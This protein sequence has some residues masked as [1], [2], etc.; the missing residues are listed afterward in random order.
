MEIISGNAIGDRGDLRLPAQ[1]DIKAD[2]ASARSKPDGGKIR[3]PLFPYW[4][5]RYRTRDFKDLVCIADLGHMGI[6]PFSG[7]AVR[8]M[9]EVLELPGPGVPA[10]FSIS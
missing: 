10:W 8:G 6:C 4:K 7:E 2:I 3:L 5:Q 1:L 9:E